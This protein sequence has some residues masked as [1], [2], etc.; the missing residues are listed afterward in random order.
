MTPMTSRDTPQKLMENET[1][2][3]ELPL[4]TQT[5]CWFSVARCL[6]DQRN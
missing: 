1:K 6:R 2:M 4:R 3:N 5:T